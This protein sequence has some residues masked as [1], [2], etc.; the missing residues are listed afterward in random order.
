MATKN[1]L[2]PRIISSEPLHEA[3][4]YCPLCHSIAHFTVNKGLGYRKQCPK[5]GNTEYLRPRV[6]KFDRH[7]QQWR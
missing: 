1:T 4:G 5:C 3:S 2:E 7:L 6:L